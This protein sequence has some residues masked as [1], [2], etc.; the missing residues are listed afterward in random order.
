MQDA[1]VSIRHLVLFITCLLGWE[2]QENAFMP[3]PTHRIDLLKIDQWELGLSTFKQ[4]FWK[5]KNVNNYCHCILSENG[6]LDTS[7]APQQTLC[8]TSPSQLQYFS[9]WRSL[10]KGNSSAVWGGN[11]LEITQLWKLLSPRIN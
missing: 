4:S 8:R 7:F 5:F 6:Y 3:I 2:Y 9:F 1:I 11:P 10:L